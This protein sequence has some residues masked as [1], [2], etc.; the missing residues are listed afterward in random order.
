[1][2]DL[3]AR[4]SEGAELSWE[5]FLQTK[6]PK[7]PVVPVAIVSDQSDASVEYSGY[8]SVPNSYGKRNSTLTPGG[9]WP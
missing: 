4:Q 2:L 9:A 5:G 7:Q 8:K 1:M 3:P 6:Y